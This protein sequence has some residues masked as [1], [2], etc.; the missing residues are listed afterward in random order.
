[1]F[2]FL[3]PISTFGTSLNTLLMKM[4]HQFPPESLRES[5]AERMLGGLV[6]DR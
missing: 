3:T 1:M 6:S 5:E 4:L 2:T